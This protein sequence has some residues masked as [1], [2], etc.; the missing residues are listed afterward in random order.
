MLA[1]AKQI[2][3]ALERLT[4]KASFTRSEASEREGDA[5]R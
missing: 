5:G 4:K 3:E 1:I 2:A